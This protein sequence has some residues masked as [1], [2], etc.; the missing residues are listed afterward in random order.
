MLHI[1]TGSLAAGTDSDDFRLHEAYAA[2]RAELDTDGM[3]ATNTTVL[4]ARG[5]TPGELLQHLATI[6]FLAAARIVTVEGLLV[7]LGSRRGVA[8]T[9]Q[10]LVDFLGTMPETNHLVLLEPAAERDDRQ[11]LER[12]ALFRTLRAIAGADVREFRALRLF[13]RDSG[14]EV[15]H[16]VLER[17][18]LHG[19]QLERTAADAL[20][21]LVGANL[22]A[23]A[24]ELDKLAQYAAKRPITVADVRALTPAAREAGMFDLVDAAVEGR[25]PVA[26]RLLRQMLDE[27]SESPQL[28][29]VMIAR[30]LRNLVRAAELVEQRAP[31]NAIGEATGVHNQWALGK[32]IRQ[33]QTLGRTGAEEALREAERTDFS[34]KTGKLDESLALE[35][36]LCRLADLAPAG[37]PRGREAAPADTRRLPTRTGGSRTARG[38][39]PRCC[40][41]RCRTAASS[42]SSAAGGCGRPRGRTS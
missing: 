38:P 6:P 11:T 14:N 36:L 2:L 4:P 10:P 17:A 31:Q 25:T 32:L 27:G 23:L 30:Q 15:A 9:W 28:V 24:S 20:S 41:A 33:A 21:E 5:L 13:G 29:L 35:L 34:V 8:D 3:L 37:P 12:S 19:I 39:A 16:W 18:A 7:S 22:W 40:R 42:S 1:F 26:L